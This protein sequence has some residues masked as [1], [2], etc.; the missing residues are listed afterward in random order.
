MTCG[1]YEIWI[2]ENYYHGS[3]NDIEKRIYNHQLKLKN[4]N[5]VNTFMRNAYNK[6]KTFEYQILVE[7]EE[8]SL[9]QWEQDYIDANYGL[10]KYMNIN[11]SAICPPSNK[12][13]SHSLETKAKMSKSAKGKKFTDEHKNKLSKAAK[14]R[15]KYACKKVVC[16]GVAF[17]SMTAV[18]KHLGVSTS[19]VS[20]WKKGARKIPEHLNLTFS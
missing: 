1:I 17:S 8:H 20:A 9:L 18:A 3:S 5:H 2:G 4:N 10:P 11:P 12:G 13:K 15:K 19:S 6:H 7:C 16:N 14:N